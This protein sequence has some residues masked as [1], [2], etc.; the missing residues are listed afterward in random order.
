MEIYTNAAS[1]V[2]ISDYASDLLSKVKKYRDTA[3]ARFNA[4]AIENSEFALIT[5]DYEIE[6][7]ATILEANKVQNLSLVFSSIK[8]IITNGFTK[9][10]AF[11]I[12]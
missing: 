12:G 11:F 10:K 3:K 1:A 8:M 7:K 4:G 5:L 6:V 9:L 2:L